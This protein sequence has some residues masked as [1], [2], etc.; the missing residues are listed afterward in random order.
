MEVLQFGEYTPDITDLD[1]GD[2]ID[3]LNVVPRR[4]GY[5]PF[6]GLLAFTSTLPG[7]CRGAFFA[8]RLDGTVS[9]FAGTATKLYLLNNSFL[10]WTDVSRVSGGAYTGPPAAGNWRF[11]Q[12]NNFVLATQKNDVLQT[13]DLTVSSAFANNAGAPPQA[14]YIAVIGGFVVL[15]GL[16]AAGQRVQWS[17]LNNTTQW[18]PGVGQAD[19]QDLP[20]GGLVRGIAGGDQY[21]VI[22]QDAAIR[23][24]TY[25][26][27]SAVVFD[28]FKITQEDGVAADGSII[29]GA[30]NQIFYYSPQGFKVIPP[31]MFGIPT[32]IGKEKIDRTFA[33]DLD[34]TNLQF[35]NGV[36][37]PTST[38]VFWT[39]K[40]LSGTAGQFDKILCYDW[41]LSR[42]V[43]LQ[44]GGQCIL[45]IPRPG[46]TLEGLDAVAPGI[47]PITGAANNGSGKIRLTLSG[48]TAGLTNLNTENRVEVYGVGG[49]TE[50]NGNWAF[51]IIDSTHIDLTGSTFVNAYTSGG[52]IGGAVDAMTTSLDN[53]LTVS[54]ARL[55]GFDASGALGIFNGPNLEAVLETPE[56]DAGQRVFVS[57]ARPFS[58]APQIFMS[59]GAKSSGQSAAAY[60]SESQ[61]GVDGTCPQRIDTRYARAKM[62]IPAGVVWTYAMGVEPV[63]QPGGDR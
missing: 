57:G 47:I 49:T 21:G 52:A 51:T 50:A 40:S 45:S 62:R 60:T 36:S 26:P 25:V 23:R 53:I 16:A 34:F 31:I 11:V 35:F 63:A 59:I 22:F 1:T 8:R 38:R 48:L 46:I 39:Y 5:G 3:I 14:A 28:I 29:A 44:A 43:L 61:I 17:D 2:S 7:P 27:G 15:G 19:F 32:P 12:F 18:T 54:I 37:D 58:D 20:D 30:G 6:P 24:L 56:Y 41:G 33:S 55:A 10:T 13:F 4:D 9:I 42:W